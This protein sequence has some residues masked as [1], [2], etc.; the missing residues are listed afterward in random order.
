MSTT[1]AIPYPVTCWTTKDQ[2]HIVEELDDIEARLR[3]LA[4]RITTIK[5]TLEQREEERRESQ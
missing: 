4:V 1:V 2:E 5:Q 3:S